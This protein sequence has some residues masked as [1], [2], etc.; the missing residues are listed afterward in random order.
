MSLLIIEAAWGCLRPL[1]VFLSRYIFLNAAF[2]PWNGQGR[3]W[4]PL[5]A[6]WG[7]LSPLK[8]SLL[9]FSK[10]CSNFARKFLRKSSITFFFWEQ[11]WIKLGAYVAEINWLQIHQKSRNFFQNC[12]NDS[13]ISIIIWFS[14]PRLFSQPSFDLA[15]CNLVYKLLKSQ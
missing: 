14:V 2:G 8:A 10:N 15:T 5:E 3:Y 11:I 1:E 7:H 12:R 9:R 4:S 13:K 6:T